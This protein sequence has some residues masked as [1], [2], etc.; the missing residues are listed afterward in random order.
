MIRTYGVRIGAYEDRVAP[1][2]AVAA[3]LMLA[4]LLSAG[5]WQLRRAEEKRSIA[6]EQAYRGGE[7]TLVLEPGLAATAGLEQLRHRRAIAAG[8]YRGDIQ[9]LLDNRI[10]KHAAGYHVLTPFQLQGS[11][12]H[13]LVNR[14]WV[15][16]GPDRGRLPAVT[17][18]ESAV[19]QEGLIVAPPA[20]GLALGASGYDGEGWPRVVQRVDLARIQE[21]LRRPLLPFVLRLSPASDH[22]YG[23]D[24]Q[25]RT[26]LT[27]ERHMGYAVQWFALAMALMGLCVWVAVKRAQEEHR[28]P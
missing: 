14:G 23:R 15:P 28:G 18:S 12:V 20:T 21:Q 25:V 16:V 13:L 6:L 27:P 11:D 4:V 22:G 17:V 5:F 19:V 8:H 3:L 1:L 2:P 26:G 9:Y 10:Q 24:W 7:E